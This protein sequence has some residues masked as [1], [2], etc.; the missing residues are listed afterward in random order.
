MKIR[1]IQTLST[2]R[3]VYRCGH[4]Y[5]L[6]DAEAQEYLAASVG[7]AATDDA[8]PPAQPK[9]AVAPAVKKVKRTHESSPAGAK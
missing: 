8:A 9:A 2:N 1:F 6:P 7:V 5:E 3:E 4:D